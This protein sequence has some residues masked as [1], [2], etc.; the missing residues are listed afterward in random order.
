MLLLSNYSSHA[1]YEQQKK[2][3]DNGV[4]ISYYIQIRYKA[5]QGVEDYPSNNDFDKIRKIPNTQ[6]SKRQKDKPPTLCD[7]KKD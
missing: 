6:D 2:R 3:R 4:S 7:A 1:R 5:K